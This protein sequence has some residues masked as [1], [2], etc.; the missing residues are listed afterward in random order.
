ML[1][2]FQI[3]KSLLDLMYYTYQITLKYPK[4]ERYTLVLDMKQ[5]LYRQMRLVICYRTNLSSCDIH[6]LKVE[7]ELF[8]IYVRI[9]YHLKYINANNYKAF[10]RKILKLEKMVSNL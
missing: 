4:V 6:Q 5:N 2:Q 3:Y 7:L 9:S 8:L 10:S 1:D